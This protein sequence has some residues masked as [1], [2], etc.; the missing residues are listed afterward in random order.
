MRVPAD[1][2]Q[3]FVVSGVLNSRFGA[4]TSAMHT[5][6][7][8]VLGTCLVT[9]RI[10]LRRRRLAR[11]LALSALLVAG[12][13]LGTRTLLAR[14]LPE[15]A[16]AAELLGGLAPRPPLAPVTLLR[17][18]PPAPEPRTPRGGRLAAIL[19]SGRLR[20]G[21]DDDSVPWAFVN[22]KGEVVGFDAEMAHSLALQL[23]VRLEFVL[24][25]R[26][27]SAF[28]RRSTPGWST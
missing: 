25:P 20:V 9:G 16:K 6:V 8:A 19:E 12:A 18:P 28:S 4:M 21:F 13:V 3:L 27:G 17:T 15:P 11:Y 2:F 24:L 23:G 10:E 7:V 1:L 5:L 26:D 22:A 14:I